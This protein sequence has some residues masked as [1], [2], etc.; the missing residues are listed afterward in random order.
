MPSLPTVPYNPDTQ[1]LGLTP[2]RL[3]EDLK[4]DR[5]IRQISFYGVLVLLIVAAIGAAYLAFVAA[6][7]VANTAA[8]EWGRSILSAIVGGAV[9]FF[10]AKK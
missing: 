10:F 1:D 9:G 5:H 2:K 4:L 6:D 3:P 8:K 7:T